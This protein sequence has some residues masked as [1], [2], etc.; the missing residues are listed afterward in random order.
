MIISKTASLR[1]LSKNFARINDNQENILK[2]I[3]ANKLLEE[4]ITGVTNKIVKS[5]RTLNVN[6]VKEHIVMLSN[7]KDI[8][9]KNLSKFIWGKTDRATKNEIK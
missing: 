5:I 3:K 4:E 2:V 8:D 9:P 6:I 7:N 1:Y